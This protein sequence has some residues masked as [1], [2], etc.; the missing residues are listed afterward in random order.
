LSI[1]MLP[2]ADGAVECG[3]PAFGEPE[4][5]RRLRGRRLILCD[6]DKL[7]VRSMLV[8]SERADHGQ[9]FFCLYVPSR[10]VLLTLV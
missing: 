8:A 2:G 1:E 5:K 6:T 9:R 7:G 3:K 10:P 4:K